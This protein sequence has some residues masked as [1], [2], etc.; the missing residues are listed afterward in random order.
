MNQILYFAEGSVAISYLFM[1]EKFKWVITDYN[2][3]SAFN[4]IC[5]VAGNLIGPQIL[6]KMLGMPDLVMAIVGYFSAMTEYIV[7]G[8]AN[9]SWELYVG[10]CC[11]FGICQT[12][13]FISCSL[14]LTLFLSIHCGDAKG[15]CSSNV[16]CTF[17]VICS[18]VWNW[19]SLFNDNVNGIIVG[20]RCST[21]VHDHLQLYPRHIS[22]C[23]QFLQRPHLSLLLLACIV[24][25]IEICFH[26]F[27]FTD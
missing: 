10:K 7:T 3:Y 6:N 27:Y 2:L 21:N 22:G 24:S 18:I 23:I 15:C 11:S 9:C 25:A 19:Q 14:C 12:R 4:V 16:P 8:L 1:R 13:Q 20:N 5:Q 26:I 17:G